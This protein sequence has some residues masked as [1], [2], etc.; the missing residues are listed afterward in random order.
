MEHCPKSGPL[1][2]DAA[3]GAEDADGKLCAVYREA[4]EAERVIWATVVGRHPGQPGHD[5]KAWEE[6][7]R[8]A[9]RVQALG[10]Q[11]RARRPPG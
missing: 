6:W 4:S 8:A 1:D 2:G 7:S 5:P 11:I 3:R 9:A 10:R